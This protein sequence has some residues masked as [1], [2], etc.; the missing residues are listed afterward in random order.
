MGE[1]RHAGRP[2]GP[3]GGLCHN[4]LAVGRRCERDPHV[5]LGLRVHILRCRTREE[6]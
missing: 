4:A 1:A 2:L 5:N 3:L 6:T